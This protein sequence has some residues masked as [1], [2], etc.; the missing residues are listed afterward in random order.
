M[1]RFDSYYANER[2]KEVAKGL[3]TL[4]NVDGASALEDL[5]SLVRQDHRT[6]QQGV[7]RDFVIPLLRQWN[8][9]NRE[10]RFDE[11]NAGT[12][13]AATVMVEALDESGITFPFI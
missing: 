2:A 13:R 12:V 1:S 3:S 11:R 9:D 10:N 7:M 4:T 5:A 6:L 8:E